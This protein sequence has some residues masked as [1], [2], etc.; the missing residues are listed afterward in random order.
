M[1]VLGV[2][3]IIAGYNCHINV[4]ID[5]F[6]GSFNVTINSRIWLRSSYTRLYTSN[7]WFT[8]QDDSLL[9]ID[10]HLN[11]GNDSI[12]GRWNETCLVY[13][14]RFNDTPVYI[15]G[16]IRQW[17]LI[18]ALTFHFQSAATVDLNNDRLLDMDRVRTVFPSFYAEKFDKNDH[19]GYLTFGGIVYLL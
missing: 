5:D 1:Y 8:T 7:Q 6:K 16:S 9:L 15:S 4:T 11:E 12:L 18:P 10:K 19:R 14:F 3:L 17:E 13:Q 2:L